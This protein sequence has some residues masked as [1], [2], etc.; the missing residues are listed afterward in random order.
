MGFDNDSSL[1]SK[2]PISRDPQIVRERILDAAQE[3]FMRV[4]YERA[5]TN[6]MAKRFGVSKATIF[7]YF[8]TKRELFESVVDR[9][10]GQWRHRIAVETIEAEEPD[11]WL[12][13]FGL[14]ALRSIL[15]EEALFVGRMAI[16]EG[17]AHEEVRNLWPRLA[18]MPIHRALAD[19][20]AHWQALG[21]VRRVSAE[22]LA[23]A[24][25]DLTL[26]G[27]V[28]RALYGS[29]AKPE[30]KA[31]EKHVQAS[32]SIFLHGCMSE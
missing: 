3:E 1:E 10:A 13:E 15:R 18:T 16:A 30:A 32:V 29:G 23:T 31:L 20:F 26:S 4:G 25:L 17:A 22:S 28:S 12:F 8:P 5:N 11:E 24:F 6:V 21:L 19:R 2:S 9:I 7:R 27:E 14:A